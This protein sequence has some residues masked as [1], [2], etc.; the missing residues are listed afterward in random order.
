MLDGHYDLGLLIAF[1]AIPAAPSPLPRLDTSLRQ[2]L[3]SFAHLCLT[4][5]CKRGCR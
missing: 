5:L 3:H 4:R 2:T 1:K